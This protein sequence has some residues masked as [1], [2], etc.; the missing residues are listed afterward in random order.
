MSLSSAQILFFGSDVS[1]LWKVVYEVL[2]L[3]LHLFTKKKK[4]GWLKSEHVFNLTLPTV[5][6]GFSQCVLVGVP[7]KS[8]WLWSAGRNW[9]PLSPCTA[10]QL[11]CHDEPE[12]W[13]FHRQL[14]FDRTWDGHRV[15]HKQ[16][17]TYLVLRGSATW[18]RADWKCHLEWMGFQEGRD[19]NRAYMP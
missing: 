11:G 19:L 14:Q 15:N 2:S 8:P 3:L 13:K 9:S 7:S 18:D 4:M 10:V 6:S 5:G 12:D 1:L 16:C 17:K